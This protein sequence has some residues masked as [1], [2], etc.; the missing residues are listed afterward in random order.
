MPRVCRLYNRDELYAQVWSK[1]LREA[2]KLYGISDVAVKKLCRRLNVP[3][4]PQGH[5]L[6]LPSD[7]E[8]DRIALPPLPESASSTFEVYALSHERVEP[9]TAATE[10][11]AIEKATAPVIVP[12]EL[13]TPHKLVAR[14]AKLLARA[15]A[16]DGLV[17]SRAAG[18]LDVNVAP[19]NVQ[20]A[21]VIADTLIKALEER[22][23]VVEVTPQTEHVIWGRTHTIDPTTRVRVED[24]WIEFSLSEPVTIAPA[25]KLLPQKRRW[26][27][28]FE[29]ELATPWKPV[30]RRARTPTGTLVLTIKTGASSRYW[31]DRKQRRLETFLNEF[32]AHLYIAADW[33]KQDRKI[34]AEEA[35]R[36]EEEEYRRQKEYLREAEEKKRVELLH[37]ELERWR[38]ARDLRDYASSIRGVIS[39]GSMRVIE[40][41]PLHEFLSFVLSY[42]DRVDPLR[43]LRE[44]VANNGQPGGRE[45]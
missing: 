29:E 21:M 24:E 44:E 41:T 7:R 2:A 14:T 20:R 27:M 32:I 3:T 4:P 42:A 28:T 11:A 19:N 37:K 35:R 8:A 40:G 30:E 36:A 9:T 15:K 34:K 10:R 26:E 45:P 33:V 17:S 22:S 31:R 13:T 5:W 38:L 39:A 1:T 6:R 23:L 18:G 16:F 25:P 12:Q 43:P